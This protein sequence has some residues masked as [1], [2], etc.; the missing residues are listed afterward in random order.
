MPHMERQ[1]SQLVLE[2]VGTLSESNDDLKK[3]T[4]VKKAVVG[5]MQFTEY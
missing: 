5:H 1:S 3:E 4:S 2:S